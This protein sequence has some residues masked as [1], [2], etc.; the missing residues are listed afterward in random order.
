VVVAL[1]FGDNRVTYL[2]KR[3]LLESRRT[4][5][6]MTPLSVSDCLLQ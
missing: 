3:D 1:V 2:I 5:D 4:S 6:P